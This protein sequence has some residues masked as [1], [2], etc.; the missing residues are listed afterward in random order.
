M[1]DISLDRARNVISC[2]VDKVNHLKIKEVQFVVEL[3]VVLK[4]G[5][6]AQLS[7]ARFTQTKG[8]ASSFRKVVDAVEGIMHERG[9]LVEDKEVWAGMRDMLLEGGG[10]A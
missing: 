10:S 6:R 1:R 7:M 3:Y 5:R 4:H 8:A 9:Y 2:R